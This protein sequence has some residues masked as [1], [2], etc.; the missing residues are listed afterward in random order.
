VAKSAEVSMKVVDVVGVGVAAGRDGGG[1]DR[2]AEGSAEELERRHRYGCF[3]R[4]EL[5]DWLT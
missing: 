5:T 1:R 3:L 2:G 4:R